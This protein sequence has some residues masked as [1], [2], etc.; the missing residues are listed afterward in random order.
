MR[1]ILLALIAALTL[2]ARAGET[3][4]IP[5]V[6]LVDQNGARVALGDVV[7]GKVAA[8]NF[9]FTSCTTIC[10]PMGANFGAVQK[11]VVSR[12]DVA[13]VSISLD[14][15]TDTPKKLKEW[16]SRFGAGPQWTLLT[17]EPDD[18]K[19][20]LAAFGVDASLDHAPLVVAMNGTTGQ[21][22]RGNGLAAPKDIVALIDSVATK[23]KN[24]AANYFGD[25]EL[26]DQD[27][28]PHRFYSDLIE[29]KVVVINAFFANCT[30]SCPVM[31]GKL[32]ALQAR[33][34]DRIG[35]DLTILSISVDPTN[36]TP[37]ALK[38]YASRFKA[39]S[40]WYFL[41]GKPENV[42]AVLKKLGQY[43]VDP[44]AHQ[45]LFLVG[46]DRTGLW[47]KAFALAETD[48]IVK[49]VESVLDDR[50]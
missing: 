38:A 49:I 32:A 20:A 34:G 43:V 40:G 22:S 42:E 33:F 15:L 18:V 10:L 4:A 28:K 6:T 21:W 3:I 47:K 12:D 2:S 41:T 8:V 44:S 17:G 37:A 29:G 35:K 48:E 36:D 31:A 19:K 26:L 16:S 46:N 23:T 45:N 30:G 39:T 7:K 27:A 13:L 50:G 14:P 5:D 9:I 11:L 1:K 24:P 25:L